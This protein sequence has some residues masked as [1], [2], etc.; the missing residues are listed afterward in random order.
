M[1]TLENGELNPDCVKSK[2]DAL[3]WHGRC[4]SL[5]G[6]N[7]VTEAIATFNAILM[8]PDNNFIR[9][10]YL[11]MK[12]HGSNAIIHL[13]TILK[14]EALLEK[15]TITAPNSGYSKQRGGIV[16]PSG[17]EA[18]NQSAQELNLEVQA[19]LFQLL[20]IIEPILLNK[21]NVEKGDAVGIL[22]TFCDMLTFQ[23]QNL[24]LTH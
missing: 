17:S 5:L 6:A 19:K 2:I 1:T 7:Q 22:D 8:P 11:S 24:Q 12:T 18:Q 21:E 14:S 20:A 4:L 3:A 9:N 13:A 23:S 15:M 16:D 10:Y